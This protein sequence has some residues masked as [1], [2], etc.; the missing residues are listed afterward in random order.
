[1]KLNLGCGNKKIEGF[2]GVDLFPC[3]QARL[4]CNIAR[5]LPFRDSCAEEILLDNVIEHIQ[6]I[7]AL[8]KELV[9]VARPGAKITI[10]TPHFTSLDSW[11]DPTHVHHLAYG[12]FNHFEK[13]NARHYVG[14]GVRI[15]GRKLSFGGGVLGLIG[16]GIFKLSPR[17]YEE[18]WCFLFRA[19]TLRFELEVV[20]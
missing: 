16:R 6:D 1:M 5:R 9:R 10:I 8:V 14:G 19:G 12:S 20:K 15:V 2:T 4:L 13:S 11:R 7:P 3:E 17:K 18:K